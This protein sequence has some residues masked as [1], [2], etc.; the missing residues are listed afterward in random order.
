MTIFAESASS[1]EVGVRRSAF[2][3]SHAMLS[4]AMLSL[5]LLVASWSTA[6]LAQS[7][8]SD[9]PVLFRATRGELKARESSIELQMKGGKLKGEKLTS[10]TAELTEVRHRLTDGDFSVGD[11]ITYSITT[12]AV[13]ADSAS[14]REGRVITL[15]TLPEAKLAGVL[16]SELDSALLAHVSRYLKNARVRTVSLTQVSIVG[17][18]ARPGYYWTPPDRPISELL[19]LAGGYALDADLHEL[20]I[21]RGNRVVLTTD[22]SRKALSTGLTVEQVDVHSGDEV[23]VPIKRRFNW[24]TITQTLFVVSSLF[25][26][27]FQFIQWYYSRQPN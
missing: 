4:H 9:V 12:E 27:G 6:A 16:R 2:T 20:E 26:A 11:R 24:S 13:I 15:S 14:V 25:F 23:K 22:A 17:A 5:A 10:L 3:T 8:P 1:R 21:R 7:P 19:T 18:V